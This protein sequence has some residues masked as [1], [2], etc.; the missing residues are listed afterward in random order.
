MPRATF[1][2]VSPIAIDTAEQAYSTTSDAAP[3]LAAGILEGLAGLAA[4]AARDVVLML[5][6][7]LLIGEHQPGALGRRRL[8][9]VLEGTLGALHGTIDFRGAGEGN[10]AERLLGSGIGYG[11][12]GFGAIDEAAVD[13]EFEFVHA[14]D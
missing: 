12:A 2:T 1:S 8:A 3:H 9:P 6:E 4:Q 14:R 13:E 10:L 7:Q 5:L 11:D